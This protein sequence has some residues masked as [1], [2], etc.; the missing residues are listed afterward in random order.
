VKQKGSGAAWFD[1]GLCTK[2]SKYDSRKAA[3]AQIAKI[4]YALAS[5]IA[6][7]FLPKVGKCA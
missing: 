7:S 5:Y 2:S 1:S 6:C 4:P 3:S